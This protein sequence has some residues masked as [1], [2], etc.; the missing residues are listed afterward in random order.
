M[1]LKIVHFLLSLRFIKY[2]IDILSVC[3]YLTTV[4]KETQELKLKILNTKTFALLLAVAPLSGVYASDHSQE[5]A[6]AQ[7]FGLSLAEYR[8]MTSQYTVMVS[9]HVSREE[10]ELARALAA[11]SMSEPVSTP[12]VDPLA[13]VDLEMQKRLEQEAEEAW[14]L[15]QI[16]QTEAQDEQAILLQKQAVAQGHA[17]FRATVPMPQDVQDRVSALR[18]LEDDKARLEAEIAT[19]AQ[20]RAAQAQIELLEVERKIGRIHFASRTVAADLTQNVEQDPH[21]I[22]R[23]GGMNKFLSDDN[24]S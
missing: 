8:Q 17:H 15:K 14:I 2:I 24:G 1:Y 5:E 21:Q 16:A 6:L 23:L 7:E 20:D 3:N 13:S 22:G 12:S 18:A 19:A 11:S 4:V 9:G 10:E